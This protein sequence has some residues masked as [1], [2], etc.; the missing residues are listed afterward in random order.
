MGVPTSEVGYTSAIARRGDH[1]S[2]YEYVVALERERE[3][4]REK[5]SLVV[6]TQQ[7]F[8]RCRDATSNKVFLC[9]DNLPIFSTDIVEH[10]KRG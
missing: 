3:R 6:N 4:E 7:N 5:N 10:T 1:E 9:I 2:S 8:I